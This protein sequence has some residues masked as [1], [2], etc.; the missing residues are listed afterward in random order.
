MKDVEVAIGRTASLKVQLEPGAVTQTVEVSASA[1]TVDVTSTASGADLSDTFYSKVPTPRN[2]SGLF[3]VAPGVT[4]SGGAGQA[5]PSIS[6]SS[7]LE[8]LYIADGVNITD[9]AFGGLGVFTR[10]YLSVGSG[11][12]LTFIKEVQ[13][14]T[15]GFEPQY[16]QATGGV[17]Q[18]V[19]KSGGRDFH[20]AIA[21]YAAPVFGQATRNQVDSVRLNQQDRLLNQG[22]YDASAELGG[23]VPGFREKLFFFGAYNPTLN[24]NYTLPAEFFQVGPGVTPIPVGLFTL[25]NGKQVY[26]RTFINNY[27]GKLTWNLSDKHKLE[28]SLF[29]DPSKTNNS[30]FR[31]PS[32]APPLPVANN[33]AYSKW[34]YG[35]RNWVV[36]YNGTFSPTWQVNANFFWNKNTFNET[37]QFPDIFGV[38]DL[39]QGNSQFIRQGL[40][41]VEDHKANDFAY[42]IDTSKIVH[43]MG[44]H[45]FTIGFNTDFMNYDD[46]KSRTGGRF[47][48]PDTGDTSI[49]G[50]NASIYGCTTATNALGCPINFMANAEFSLKVDDTCVGCPMMNLP[51]GPHAVYLSNNRGEFGPPLAQTEGKYYA[52][53]A[54]DAW[55]INKYVSVNYGLRWEQYHMQGVQQGYTFTD[56]WAPRLGVS[57]D[58]WG[59]RKSKVY[60][61]FGRYN[62]QMPLDAAIRSLSAE[63]D[64]FNL[65]FAPVNVG[66]VV[67][68]NAN[69]SINIQPDLSHFLNGIAANGNAGGAAIFSNQAATEG[70]APGTKMQYEDEWVAGFERDLGHGLVFSARYLDRRL[71]RVVE[72]VSGISPEGAVAGEIQQFVITNPSKN[73]DLF[74]N[75]PVPTLAPNPGACPPGT[76]FR[77]Q[78]TGPA[79]DA[80][81]N[82]IAGGQTLCFSNAANGQAPG[83]PGAD[84]LA[85]GFINPV[86]NYQAVE[87]EL[88][89]SF[90][91]GWLMRAN[92]RVARLQGNYE[93]AFRNDNGQTYPSISSLF[94]FVAGS[95]NLLGDQFAIGPLNTDR[96]HVING[97]FSYTFD[98]SAVKGL[99]L[100]TGIRVQGGTPI[101]ELAAH[102]VYGN[103]GEVP[104]GGRGKLG[105]TPVS[106]QADLHADYVWKITEKSHLKAGVDLF[107]L[108]NIEPITRID[109]FRDLNFQ[110]TN[111]NPDFQTP[112]A[113]QNPFA[114]RFSLRW[115]F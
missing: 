11:I 79:V 87:I 57:V 37:P 96:R 105:R 82:L 91:K 26:A 110:G 28:T 98:H 6:G 112:L 114:S 56:N 54:S 17:V 16:G 35:T 45:T 18:I 68:P 40:G 52:G 80:N 102:P 30:N 21:G 73:T 74:A 32:L 61:N 100:G 38:T 19:T 75:Q 22:A 33:T 12:N 42:A 83:T 4:D 1:V 10:Q 69:G 64:I 8:N 81:G 94:D 78:P 84:G 66:G 5:N 93:G 51:G 59:N 70:F 39:T 9:A 23:Y 99:T 97:F 85:D 24:T 43:K 47:V 77:N 90:S 27:A 109:Q 86:R 101:N 76:A 63:L 36:R 65:N 113:Y 34:D 62:Y 13:V 7:G 49:G 58:P 55:T 31:P 104:I 111:S 44:Q 14:K 67:T 60:A 48:I 2:V 106:G 41:F 95:F 71:R 25:L 20:G 92:Y 103:G 46:S 89:K 115:E 50:R 107:N 3:Y 72:D 53:Y 108:A 15:G 29:G 88:N